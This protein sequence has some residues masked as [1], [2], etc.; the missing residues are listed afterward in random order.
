[1]AHPYLAHVHSS[2][3]AT[4]C[5]VATPVFVESGCKLLQQNYLDFN[6]L[7]PPKQLLGLTH[8]SRDDAFRI[9]KSVSAWQRTQ[10]ITLEDRN[11]SVLLLHQDQGQFKGLTTPFPTPSAEISDCLCSCSPVLKW[12]HQEGSGFPHSQNS[13]RVQKTCRHPKTSYK[14]A[15][16]YY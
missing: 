5:M 2:G 12:L 6:P 9:H 7:S 14:V 1:M 10:Y 15:L 8:P 4:A 16:P 13:A 11:F 3:S